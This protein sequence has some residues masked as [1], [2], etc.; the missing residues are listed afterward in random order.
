MPNIPKSTEPSPTIEQFAGS[1]SFQFQLLLINYQTA[2]EIKKDS[3][4]DFVLEDNVFDTFPRGYVDIASPGNSL[5]SSISNIEETLRATYI[6]RNDARDFLR[7]RMAP[8]MQTTDE[9]LKE[10]DD[11]FHTI[12]YTF[13]IYSIKDVVHDGSKF[14]RLYFWDWRYQILKETNCFFTTTNSLTGN[15]AHML[16]EERK[17]YT[18]TA[19]Q[20][21]IKEVIGPDELFASTWDPGS[22]LIHYTSPSSN[23][24]ID[25]LEYL[26]SSHVSSIET[27]NQE[28]ILSLDRY[29]SAWQ[30]TPIGTIFDYAV[31]RQK[32]G[33]ETAFTP[34]V[35]QSEIF[36]I[37]RDIGYEES[38]SISN[39]PTSRI[40]QDRAFYFNY[41][42]GDSSC[43]QDY[44]YIEMHGDINQQILNTTP[45][46]QY[47]AKSKSFHINMED[48][49]I[50]SII[51][52]A[53]GKMINNMVVDVSKT[54]DVPISANF[55]FQRF[56]NLNMDHIFTTNTDR[57]GALAVS[58]NKAIKNL[59]SQS[60]AIEFNVP[61][62]TTRRSNRFISVLHNTSHD[63]ASNKFN[64]KVDG[65]Y[66]V[67]SAM[68]RIKNG[69]Y[70]NKIAAV[71]PYNHTQISAIDDDVLKLST[72]YHDNL[73]V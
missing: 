23:R 33:Q 26:V 63:T 59:L 21:L 62:E 53:Q 19:I 42:L 31:S 35:W 48:T 17:I 41:D 11:P 72:T 30:L 28:C 45:V 71:K 51:S 29:T 46:H 9:T 37:G 24:S 16:D 20:E 13:T 22:R 34:G 43:I 56:A 57:S 52:H 14:K 4:Y 15:P 70:M 61:G 54:D 1:R 50:H 27:E 67:V 73:K 58:R 64:D 49:N 2:T 25:D 40:P 5:E 65:Q 3:I 44:R 69:A 8:N 10:L 18:G 38:H 7:F 12:D 6:F 39:N 60:N 32:T 66:Y 55:D 68:H 47:S 36:T